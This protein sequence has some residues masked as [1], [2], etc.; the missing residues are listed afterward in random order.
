M[1]SLLLLSR[2]RYRPHS[3]VCNLNGVLCCLLQAIEVEVW[4]DQ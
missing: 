3:L 2:H 4:T 1:F